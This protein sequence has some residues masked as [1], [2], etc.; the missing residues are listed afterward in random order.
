MLISTQQYTEADPTETDRIVTAMHKFVALAHSMLQDNF[1]GLIQNKTLG[2]NFDPWGFGLSRTH[3]LP[4]ALQ[5]LYENHPRG[6]EELIWETMELMF[7]GGRKGS[8]DWTTF[9]V[10][11]VF[12]KLGTPNFKTSGFTH[13][14]NLA[15]G[16]PWHIN[17]SIQGGGSDK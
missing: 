12:P 15:Q 2:D 17:L 4:L 13:G 8:R 7:V 9:F 10:E 1:T 14:V 11:G 3:E 6:N 5:W 16:M